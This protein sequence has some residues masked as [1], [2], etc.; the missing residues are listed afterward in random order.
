MKLNWREWFWRSKRQQVLGTCRLCGHSL[1]LCD[2]CHGNWQA[3]ACRECQLGLRCPKHT[4]NW[5]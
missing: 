4:N 3:T 1:E 5:I 2:T